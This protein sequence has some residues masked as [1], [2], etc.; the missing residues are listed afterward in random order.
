[1]KRINFIATLLAI[2]VVAGCGG[3]KETVI[4]GTFTGKPD[5]KTIG[6]SVPLSGTSYMGFGDTLHL[7]ETGNF[8]L[9][10]TIN[11][12][13]FIKIWD[14]ETYAA[15]K[16]LI[17]PGN[18][19]HIAADVSKED[20]M[21]VQIS[22]ANEK[23]QMLYSSLPD[24]SYIEFEA[25]RL[26][27]LQ[28]TS[29]VSIHAKIEELK[30]SDLSEF[31][32]LLDNKEISQSFFD[33]IKIDRDFYY[34]AL[35]AN[36]SVIKAYWMRETKQFVLPSGENVLE[37]LT[38]IYAQYPPDSKQ[39]IFSSFWR[40]YATDYITRYKL[41]IQDDFDEQKI[42]DLY[43]NGM[44]HTSRINESKNHL[45]G[46]ALEFFQATYLCDVGFQA[47]HE[48][49]LI[50]LF[51]QFEKDYPN[52]E[53]AKFIKPMI[54]EIVSYHQIIEKPFDKTVQ[55]VAGYENINTLEE[56]LTL[57]KGKKIYID[58]WATW[59][60][61]CKEEFKHQQA[62]KKILDEQN[63]QQLYISIDKDNR[64]QQWKE[65]IKFYGLSGMHIRA[66][67]ELFMDLCKR[68]DKNVKDPYISIPWYILIDENGNIIKEH[69]KTPS[70]IIDKPEIISN[71]F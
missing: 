2:L 37:N 42:N 59:C 17:E 1:M 71:I 3:N 54:D 15:T 43:T 68:F 34:T 32:E 29:L 38:K 7:D 66:N 63:I 57:L 51:E 65:G 23:G 9:K 20:D 18:N 60:S 19:Y 36:V 30:Q 14:A 5:L 27:L 4:T 45:T 10:F 13:S 64:D 50:A 8:E 52:S 16:I 28:D 26:K 44:I 48:K 46:K 70:E 62:L 40:E 67:E 11:Q 56:A 69:A 24:P 53:Y 33:L 31:K 49:E 58:V 6:Y 35:E 21:Q 39:L 61:P 25:K 22:G 47:N 55:F 12:P 41:Y